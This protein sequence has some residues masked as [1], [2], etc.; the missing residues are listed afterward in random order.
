MGRSNETKSVK[1]G[2]GDETKSVKIGRSD[3]TKSVKMGRSNDTKW[4]GVMIKKRS[5]ETNPLRHCLSPAFGC[6]PLPRVW[7]DAVGVPRKADAFKPAHTLSACKTKFA[8]K[9]RP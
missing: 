1:M 6:E 8:Q 7:L 5:D 4:E 3:E 9:E 2:N